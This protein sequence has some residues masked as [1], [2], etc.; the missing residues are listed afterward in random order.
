MKTAETL[1]VA[2]AAVRGL[3]DTNL[4][5][6]LTGKNIAGGFNANGNNNSWE[7]TLPELVNMA[8]GGKGGVADS[9]QYQGEGGLMGALK[10]NIKVNGLDAAVQL[11]TIPIAFKVAKKVLAKPL[12][13]PANRAMR[14]A[15]IREVKL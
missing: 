9:Y 15:G 5:T 2:N 12:I 7:L 8:L 14:A 6:F 10:R 4:P 11:I 13:N 3:T 1:L